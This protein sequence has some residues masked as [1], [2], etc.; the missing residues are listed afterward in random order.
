MINTTFHNAGGKT[1]V[2]GVEIGSGGEGKVFQVQNNRDFVAKIY[3][4][5]VEAEK[6]DKLRVMVN[7]HSEQLTK[8]SSWPIDVL[9]VGKKTVAGFIMPKIAGYKEIHMLYGPKTRLRDFPFADW[10]FLVHVA[11]NLARAFNN[12]HQTGQIV[13]DVNHNNIVVSSNGMVKF[14]DC[15]SFQIMSSGK[16]FPCHVGVMTHQP[17]EFQ[18]KLSLRGL[19]RTHN[20]DNFGLAVLIF[21][22]LFMGRHPFSGQ[23]IGLGEMPLEKAI[24][25]YRFAYGKNALGKLMKQPPGTLRLGALPDKMAVLFERAFSIEGSLGGRPRPQEW[26]DAIQVLSNHL[27]RCQTNKNHIYYDKLKVCPWCEIDNHFHF[28]LP[29]CRRLV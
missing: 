6:A 7:L 10:A 22:L 27:K 1:F 17:P 15:D 19:M 11:G 3:Y 4:K 25:E 24:K 13:G 5:Q 28:R 12:I 16:V 14:I 8:V 9:F 29:S 20:H 26:I 18:S 23:F 2:M 21:Q